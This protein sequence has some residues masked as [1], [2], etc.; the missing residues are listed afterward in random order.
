MAKENIDVLPVVSNDDG[1]IIGILSYRDIIDT[2]KY[3]LEEHE[4]KNPAISLKRKGLKIM[5]RGKQMVSAFNRM[6]K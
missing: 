1:T 5:L 2:Y 6:G 3:S 4:K